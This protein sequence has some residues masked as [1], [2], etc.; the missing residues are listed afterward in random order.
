M[1]AEHGAEKREEQRVYRISLYY[2]LKISRNLK[3]LLKSLLK[4]GV[5]AKA[6]GCSW[7]SS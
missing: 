7:G 1:C 4:K 6:G 3:M 5:C 2:L